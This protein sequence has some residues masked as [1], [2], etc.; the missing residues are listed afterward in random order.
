MVCILFVLCI[1]PGQLVM[2]S[3]EPLTLACFAI[4]VYKNVKLKIT[5]YRRRH[6]YRNVY[7]WIFTISLEEGLIVC[8][9]KVL[10]D[11]L[12]KQRASASLITHRYYKYEHTWFILGNYSSGAASVFPETGP[13]VL[14]NAQAPGL[15]NRQLLRLN[16][17]SRVP[18]FGS[19]P[20]GWDKGKAWKKDSR[21]YVCLLLVCKVMIYRSLLRAGKKAQSYC[22]KL[23][24]L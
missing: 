10:H 8:L 13:L 1:A 9:S 5:G 16:S 2:P 24:Y 14:A 19:V 15:Q 6:S 21:V 23:Q 17:M 3:S 20:W 4:C 12:T 11:H 18:P 22:R 7:R